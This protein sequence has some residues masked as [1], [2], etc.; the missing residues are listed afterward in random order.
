M[1]ICRLLSFD[2]FRPP[3]SSLTPV[4]AVTERAT[5]LDFM[6]EHRL[7]VQTSVSSAGKPQAAVVG[8]IVTDDFALFFDTLD[9]TR[10]TEN[11]RRNPHFAAVIGGCIEGEERTVQFEGV[12]DE[13]RGPELESLKRLYFARFP[14]G[15]ERLAWPG[16]I[17][18]RARPTWV[19]FSDFR[20]TPPAIIEIDFT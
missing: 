10:K 19:R 7:A 12:A 5:I 17:Y 4:S 16:L 2:A 13:P 1:L 18:V 9:S 6:R 8:F 15:P 14:D 11:L 3:W 20:S